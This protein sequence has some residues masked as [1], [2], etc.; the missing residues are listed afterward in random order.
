MSDIMIHRKPCHGV[1]RDVGPCLG[2]LDREGGKVVEVRESGIH[3]K[4]ALSMSH[5]ICISRGP[6]R[7]GVRR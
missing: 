5:L 7:A 2:D 1:T 6:A 4:G 3:L